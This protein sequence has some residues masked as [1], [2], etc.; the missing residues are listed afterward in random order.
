MGFDVELWEDMVFQDQTVGWGGGGGIYVVQ[1]FGG[2]HQVLLNSTCDIGE[3]K[4][5]T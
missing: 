4:H 1:T 2:S 3:D 5:P